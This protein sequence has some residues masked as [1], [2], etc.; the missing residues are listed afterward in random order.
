[1]LLISDDSRHW[2]RFVC[3]HLVICGGLTFET[4][5]AIVK[6]FVHHDWTD[7]NVGMVVI[8]RYKLPMYNPSTDTICNDCDKRWRHDRGREFWTVRKMS[9]NICP[10]GKFSSKM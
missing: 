10:V 3:S 1:M 4:L 2:C 8:N 7:N 9:K 6:S 5:K